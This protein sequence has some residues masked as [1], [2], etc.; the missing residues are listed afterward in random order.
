MK[1]TKWILTCALAAAMSATTIRAQ[2]DVPENMG[3]RSEELEQLVDIAEMDLLAD[4]LDS[5]LRE[6]AT[7][8]C[9]SFADSQMPESGLF[10]MPGIDMG[11]HGDGFAIGNMGGFGV[12]PIMGGFGNGFGFGDMS[13][14]CGFP[15]MAG[16]GGMVGFCGF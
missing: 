2:K 16:Y 3:G 4:M 9:R 7:D 6:E 1:T 11:I 13:G 15:M 8:D 14:F 12:F 5:L 10:R